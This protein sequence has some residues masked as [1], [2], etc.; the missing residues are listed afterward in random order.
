MFKKLLE[1]G[2][3]GYGFLKKGVLNWQSGLKA[4]FKRLQGFYH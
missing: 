1:N 2:R 3:M 4:I